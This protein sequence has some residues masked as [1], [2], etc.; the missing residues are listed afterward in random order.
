M[1]GA[2]IILT[3][4]ASFVLLA[5]WGVL[6]GGDTTE[7]AP[8]WMPLPGV[9]A[10]PS[11]DPLD[12]KQICGH[13]ATLKAR[14]SPASIH[15]T[16]LGYAVER[17]GAIDDITVAGTSGSKALDEAVIACVATLRFQPLKIGRAMTVGWK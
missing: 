7:I 10:A 1:R 2:A 14:F 4:S 13:A 11:L 15:T 5:A 16:I 12:S 6:R 9:A 17:D 8:L 3:V